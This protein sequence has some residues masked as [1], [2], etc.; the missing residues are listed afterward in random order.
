MKTDIKVAV[1]GASGFIGSHILN[2]LLEHN[3]TCKGF[4]R[5]KNPWRINHLNLGRFYECSSNINEFLSKYSPSIIINAATYGGYS[6]ENNA[7]EINVSNTDLI[8]E[9]VNWAKNRDSLIIQLGSSSEYGFNSKAPSENQIC[10]PNSEYAKAKLEVTN[11]LMSSYSKYGVKSIVLRL[12]SV[13]GPLEDSN[14]MFPTLVKNLINKEI[15]E[16]AN[17]KISRD[18]IHIND[19][20]NLIN[21]LVNKNELIDKFDIYNVATGVKTTLGDL[22]ILIK[23]IKE[24]VVINYSFPNRAWDLEDWY[25]NPQKIEKVFNWK[26]K[27]VVEKGLQDMLDYYSNKNYQK[28]LGPEYSKFKEIK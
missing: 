17:P 8:R 10:K 6:F 27:I 15:I 16:L 19:V 5:S 13:Y 18:F 11:T 20:L 22:E 1:I 14:R 26:F 28:F 23:K 9:I 24:D 2:Y 12:Y 3:I 7:T 21:I 25:G 4:S